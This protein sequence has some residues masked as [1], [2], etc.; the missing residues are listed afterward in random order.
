MN[1][2]TKITLARI[3]IVPFIVVTFYV[4][5][6]AHMLVAALLFTIASCTDFVDGKLA[7]KRNEVT[8]FGKLLDPVADKVLAAFAMIMVACA[9]LLYN[10]YGVILVCIITSR[11]L[12]IGVF[13]VVAATSG[14]VL[15]ADKWGKLKTIFLNISLP[16]VM[17][18]GYSIIIKIAGNVLFFIGAVLAVV[19]GANY[20]IKNKTVI[21]CKEKGNG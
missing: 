21:G 17:I 2:P 13:R 15:A 4:N 3:L 7:R 6:P 16:I 11:E 5:F 1:L 20:I 8:D 12:L 10:P 19:S 18:G 14:I 9:G